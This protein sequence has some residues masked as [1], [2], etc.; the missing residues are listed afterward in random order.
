MAAANVAVAQDPPPDPPEVT[1]PSTPPD[2]D[3]GSSPTID[4][5]LPQ[6]SLYNISTRGIV[7]SIDDRKLIGGF[8][9]AGGNMRVLIRALG[10]SVGQ[11]DTGDSNLA[12]KTVSDV[13]VD[14][15]SGGTT[16]GAN[17]DFATSPNL[18][19]IQTAN[20]TPG[21]STESAVVL[22]LEP[23]N[24]TAIVSAANDAAEGIGMVEIFDFSQGSSDFPGY[25]GNLSTRGYISDDSDEVLIGGFIVQDGAESA[26][27]RGIGPQLAVVDSNLSNKTIENPRLRVVE[28]ATEIAANN[29][30][31][32]AVYAS[33]VN[34]AG[35]SPNFSVEAAELLI[36][37]TTGGYTVIIDSANSGTGVAQVELFAVDV[38]A[39]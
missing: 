2:S 9:V 34:S 18:T 35:L 36:Q 17:D 3:P 1:V 10:P 19:D 28:G 31:A 12:N 32:T 38:V 14:V 7:G 37:K 22:E 13:R 11:A 23:G 16:I 27:V 5:D 25:F 8:Q 20:L 15:V 4:P 39:E 30:H 26:I 24:Y 21:N 33:S 6:G 29:D